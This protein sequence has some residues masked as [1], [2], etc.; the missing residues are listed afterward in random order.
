MLRPKS[1]YLV[2]W[3]IVETEWDHQP[4]LTSPHLTSP[5]LASSRLTSPH[6]ALPCLASPHL[7]SSCLT[8]PYLTLLCLTSPHLISPHLISPH[9]T[10]VLYW[11]SL[12]TKH[13]THNINIMQII[14]KGHLYIPYFCIFSLNYLG[15]ST[16]ILDMNGLLGPPC[17]WEQNSDIICQAITTMFLHPKKPTKTPPNW[18]WNAW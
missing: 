10:F 13:V 18:L 9:L 1:N 15:Q 3:D 17:L 8:L 6:L 16:P 12:L 11:K 7:T 5:P 14:L 2:Y 4:Y